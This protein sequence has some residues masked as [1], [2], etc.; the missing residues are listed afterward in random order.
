MVAND[1]VKY[2]WRR[3]P[4]RIIIPNSPDFFQKVDR[5]LRTVRM[6]RENRSIEFIRAEFS[7]QEITV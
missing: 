5:T 3:H 7:R 1:K 4:A 6:M 2:A